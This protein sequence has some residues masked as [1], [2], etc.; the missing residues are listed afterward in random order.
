MPKNKSEAPAATWHCHSTVLPS[1]VPFIYLSSLPLQTLATQLT[2]SVG[3]CWQITWASCVPNFELF[4]ELIC[5]YKLILSEVKNDKILSQRVFI[6]LNRADIGYLNIKYNI[7]VTSLLLPV[8]FHHS[9]LCFTKT[10]KCTKKQLQVV[11]TC[12]PRT[13]IT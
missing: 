8:W 4:N 2:R 10:L 9:Q 1:L 7:L 6:L 3:S 12:L 5:D 13:C 11:M